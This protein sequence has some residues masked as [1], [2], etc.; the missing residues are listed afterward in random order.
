MIGV[1]IKTIVVHTSIKVLNIS[2]TKKPSNRNQTVSK[3]QIGIWLHLLQ[4]ANKYKKI[5]IN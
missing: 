2:K 1:K 4:K 5:N 3:K